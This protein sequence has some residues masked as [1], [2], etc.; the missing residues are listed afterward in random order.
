MYH[1]NG[2]NLNVPLEVYPP[3]EDSLLL[4]NSIIPRGRVL[5]IGT[6]SGI[7]AI[8]LAKK[9]HDVVATDLNPRALLAARENAAANGVGGRVAVVRADLLSGIKGPFDTVVFNPPYLPS[10]PLGE[11]R[12][13]GELGF[14]GAL[15]RLAQGPGCG[16]LGSRSPNR[17]EED[18]EQR[19]GVMGE[20]EDGDSAHTDAEE[21]QDPDDWLSRSW[22]GGKGGAEVVDRFMGQL[23]PC[24]ASGGRGY[25]VVSSLTDF[26]LPKG[27]GLDYRVIAEQ[28]EPFEKLYV[29]EVY[30]RSDQAR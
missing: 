15:D 23:S 11:L 18:Y 30:R 1:Y 12:G 19:P 21:P 2:I 26:K 7:V 20:E 8:T 13:V 24:L 16:Q 10:R 3:Q 29:L 4:A 17:I 5:E 9:G 22:M 14:P 6:G 25:L 27:S 28:T